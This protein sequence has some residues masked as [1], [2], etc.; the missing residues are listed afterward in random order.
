MTTK[1][2]KPLTG[3]KVLIIALAA[4]GVVIGANMSM[5]FFSLGIG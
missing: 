4:F 1:P 5:L 3:R 2:A